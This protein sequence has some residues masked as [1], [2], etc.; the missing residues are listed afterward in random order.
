M[1]VATAIAFAL[2]LV[3]TTLTNLAYLRQHDAAAAL[4]A[5]SLRHPLHSIGLL[6]ANHRWLLAFAMESCGFLF[7]AAALALAPLALVQSVVAGGIG[8]LAYMSFRLVGRRLG[9]RRLVG[10]VVSVLGLLA[11][12]VSLAGGSE[13]GGSGSTAAV[14]LWIGGTAVLAAIVLLL[15]R[16][17]LGVAVASALA[18][19][20]CFSVGDISTKLATQGGARGAFVLTLI[21]G[22][23][24]VPRCCRS[25]IRPVPR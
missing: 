22:Y 17:V 8:L 14:L 7:Y 4:P 6:L 11:L 19:G 2:A 16:R 23:A 12:A 9:T 24:L 18:G 10:V 3:S 1:S 13:E 21:L 25:A 20:L 5:L 15:G